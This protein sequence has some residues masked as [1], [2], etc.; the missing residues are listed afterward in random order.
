LNLFLLAPVPLQL[1]HL[2]LADA[3][4]IAF[5]LVVASSPPAAAS[6]AG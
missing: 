2:T 3:T 6:Q 4:W 1:V 5:V